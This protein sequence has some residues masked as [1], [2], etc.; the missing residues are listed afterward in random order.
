MWA[1]NP[2]VFTMRNLTLVRPLL[3]AAA[4]LCAAGMLTACDEEGPAEQLGEK[5]DESA[6]KAGDAVE[7]ATDR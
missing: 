2:G 4:V 5:I 1:P 3:V 6:K 7:K